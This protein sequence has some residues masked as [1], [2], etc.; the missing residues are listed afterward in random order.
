[1]EPRNRKAWQ[2]VQKLVTCNRCGDSQV[3][4]VQS[5]DGK[6]YLATAYVVAGGEGFQANLTDPHFKHCGVKHA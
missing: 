2:P 4:W 5:K 3:A 1:M 6:W